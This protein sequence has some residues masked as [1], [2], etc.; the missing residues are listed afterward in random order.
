MRQIAQLTVDDFPGID[1]VRFQQWKQALLSATWVWLTLTALLSTALI[2]LTHFTDISLGFL[3][4]GVLFVAYWVIASL[5]YVRPNQLAK[6]LGLSKQVIRSARRRRSPIV[7]DGNTPS[8]WYPDPYVRH[9]VRYWSGSEWTEHV[10][11]QGETSVDGGSSFESSGSEAYVMEA[12]PL[13][14]LKAEVADLKARCQSSPSELNAVNLFRLGC[15]YADLFD[16]TCSDSHKASALKY[17][18][19]AKELDPAEATMSEFFG[20]DSRKW[21]EDP[22]FRSFVD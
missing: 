11:D 3:G 5:V 4:I 7:D 12:G 17:M 13:G 15:L 1:A 19:R 20:A 10:S 14:A 18:T 21:V 16:I 6:E 8:G 2:V 22:E 9:E